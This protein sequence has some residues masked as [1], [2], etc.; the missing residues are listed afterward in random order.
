MGKITSILGEILP[1][2][3]QDLAKCTIY[4][5]SVKI[6]T[7]FPHTG[8]NGGG[9]SL[10]VVDVVGRVAAAAEQDTAAGAGRWWWKQQQGS[11]T[12]R[13]ASG[14]EMGCAA[15]VTWTVYMK[16][17]EYLRCAI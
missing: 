16:H 13:F 10:P 1:E 6:G 12:F 8:A 2:I 7:I 4:E 17:F 5:I 3:R 14:G 11:G 15:P 9:A